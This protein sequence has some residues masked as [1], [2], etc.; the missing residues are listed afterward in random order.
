[1]SRIATLTV[2]TAAVVMLTTGAQASGPQSSTQTTPPAA[3]QTTPPTQ[4]TGGYMTSGR[5]EDFLKEVAQASQVEIESSKLAMTKAQNAEVKAF[6]EKLVKEHTAASAELQGLVKSRGAEWK[7]D[8]PKFMEKKQKHESLQKLSGAEF[9][10]EY[11]EDMISDH[12]S[13]IALF[14]KYSLNA[15]DTALK[16]FADNTQPALREHLKM[17]RDLRARVIK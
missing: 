10:K 14:A 11:L 6:A 2:A 13:T 12:E 7:D 4:Q 16:S 1:M 15:S 3:Q 5:D 17:A 8:D 9:D